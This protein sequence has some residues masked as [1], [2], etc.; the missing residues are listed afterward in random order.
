M[1]SDDAIKSPKC[2]ST[3]VHAEKRGWRLATGF[4]GSGKIVLT[5]LKC[6]YEFRPGQE[7]VQARDDVVLLWV[8]GV[9]AAII[10]VLW[11]VKLLV[12]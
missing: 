2:S 7:R 8:F 12:Y 9:F 10:A 5:C 4:F 1:S 11:L 3:Q 6:G